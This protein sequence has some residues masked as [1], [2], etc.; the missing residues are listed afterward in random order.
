MRKLT[1][2]HLWIKPFQT[3]Q[4]FRI[5]AIVVLLLPT[6]INLDVDPVQAAAPTEGWSIHFEAGMP[7]LLDKGRL[8][9]GASSEAADGYDL[10]DDPHPPALPENYLDLYTKHDQNEVGWQ[11]QPLPT[12]RYRAEYSSPLDSTDRTIDLYLE[13]DQTGFVILSWSAISDPLLEAFQLTLLDV[14]SD[15]RIDLRTQRSYRVEVHSGSN[16]F[17]LLITYGRPVSAAFSTA[18][19]MNVAR[20]EDGAS[21]V[22]YSSV[23]GTSTSVRPENAIDYNTSSSWYAAN[24]QISDQWITVKL[25]GAT[26]HVIDRVILGGTNYSTGPREFE[27]LVSLSGFEDDDFTTIY[28]GTVPQTNE[29]HTFTFKPV[30]AA[31]VKLFVQNNWGHASQL[32]VRHFQVWTRDRDGGIVSLLEGPPSTIV[33]VS[34]EYGAGNAADRA[35][36]DNATTAWRSANGSITN[37]WFTVELGGGLIY[38]ID[39]VRLMSNNLDEIPQDFEVR[40]STTTLDE[41]AF[42]PV[43][44]TKPCRQS[45][46][47]SWSITTTAVVGAFASTPSRYSH[48]IAPMLPEEMALEP[49]SWI[50]PVTTVLAPMRKMPSTS[51]PPRAGSAQATKTPTSGS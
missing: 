46:F 5:L 35:I 41:A 4:L 17:Q 2:R 19:A 26:P 16:A 15:V 23:S 40:V 37:Q 38:T 49:L 51:A 47:N 9:L 3:V 42:S 34:S 31:Y 11:G 12:L 30:R 18:K 48:P 32:A 29:N 14:A 6:L 8:T 44:S 7:D 1:S 20:W 10:Y 28:S 36:D 50:L 39:R 27:V 22:E 25:I 13:T 45:T 21:V 33:D 24:G 43:H